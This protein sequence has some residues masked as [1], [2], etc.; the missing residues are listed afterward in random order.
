MKVIQR[1]YIKERRIKK[2]IT[3][4]NDI[5]ENWNLIRDTFKISKMKWGIQLFYTVRHQESKLVWQ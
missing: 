1:S 3:K 4:V 2:K 5:S